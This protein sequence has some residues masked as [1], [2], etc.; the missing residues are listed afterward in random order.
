MDELQWLAERFEEHR[1]HLRAVAYRILGSLTEADDAVQEAWLRLT[2]SDPGKVENLG[3][4]LTTIVTRVSLN[5][6][7]SRRGRREEPLGPDVPEP[8]ITP[9]EGTHPEHEALLADGIGRALQVVMQALGPSERLAYVLHD[10]FD[11]PFEEIA[12]ILERS[13]Q[14]ARQLASRARRRIRSAGPPHEGDLT[15]QQV[16]VDAFLSAAR[17]GDFDAVI[18]VLHPD[19]VL[20]ASGDPERTGAFV[21]VRGATAVARRALSYARLGLVEKPAL[22]NG[23]P[24]VGFIRH[25]QPFSVIGFIVAGDRITELDILRI[26]IASKR[27]DLSAFQEQRQ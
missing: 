2:R 6:V 7:R 23:A 19:V 1:S 24:G 21:K 16:V 9:S 4:W 18:A 13:T 26:R 22:I 25:G 5:M 20:R 11:M 15:G 8:I 10:V 14:A 17:D 12:L 27:L 3:A